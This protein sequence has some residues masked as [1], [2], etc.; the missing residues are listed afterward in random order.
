MPAGVNKDPP[1]SLSL[2]ETVRNWMASWSLLGVGGEYF[3]HLYLSMKMPGLQGPFQMANI[4]FALYCIVLQQSQI[5]TGHFRSRGSSKTLLTGSYHVGEQYF[6]GAEM[7]GH[8]QSLGLKCCCNTKNDVTDF[9]YK[10]KK[11]KISQPLFQHRSK[12]N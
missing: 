3:Y 2:S 12:E 7:L 5:D 6:S 1:S 9:H 4:L 8:Q 10:T 11:G